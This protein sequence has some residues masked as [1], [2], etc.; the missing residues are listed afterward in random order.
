MASKGT[1]RALA[2]LKNLDGLVLVGADAENAF[3]AISRINLNELVL[4]KLPAIYNWFFTLYGYET[5][6][7]YDAVHRLM[8]A[9]GLFQ[10]VASSQTFFGAGKWS[11]QQ[12]TYQLMTMPRELELPSSALSITASNH[13]HNISTNA[14][15]I[16]SSNHNISPATHNNN[17]YNTSNRA[18]SLYPLN[19]DA[20]TN[21]NNNNNILTNAALN[22]SATSDGAV[23]DDA[24]YFQALNN[25]ATN[26]NHQQLVLNQHNTSYNQQ[27]QHNIPS[28]EAMERWKS[29]GAG[30]E[31]LEVQDMSGF[32]IIFQTDWVDDGVTL[33]ESKF[34]GEYLKCQEIAYGEWHL[35][36]NREKTNIIQHTTNKYEIESTKMQCIQY[37]Y[38][39][40]GEL[41]YLGIQ[42]GPKH[43][44][45]KHLDE[46]YIKWVKK[47]KYF[48]L[49]KDKQIRN[50]LFAKFF[51]F[52]KYHY[53]LANQPFHTS[54]LPEFQKV[55]KFITGSM[56]ANVNHSKTAKVQI[57]IA[58]KRGGLGMRAPIFY[59]PASRLNALSVPEME[60]ERMFDFD[61]EQMNKIDNG[62]IMDINTLTLSCY[63]Q[64]KT[65]KLAQE[66]EA[67]QMVEQIKEQIASESFDYN[68]EHVS[69]R[70]LLQLMDKALERQFYEIATLEDKARMKSLSITGATSWLRTPPNPHYGVKYN[71]L[72]YTVLTA[73]MLGAPILQNE[74]ICNRCSKIC[75]KYG[76]HALICPNGPFMINRHNNICGILEG[77]GKRAGYRVE[78]EVVVVPNND[79]TVD[80]QSIMNRKKPGDLKYFNWK[81]M[82]GVDMMFDLTVGSIFCKTYKKGAAQRRFYV[83]DEK[84]K[85]KMRKYRNLDLQNFEVLAIENAGGMSKIFRGV[86]QELATRISLYKST[87]YSI[88][89]NQLRTKIVATLMKHNAKMIIASM[90]CT[91]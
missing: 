88:I 14:I 86:L 18:V 89:I 68:P 4:A 8:A 62:D 71:N 65:A 85:Q 17:N 28:D 91:E 70:E 5:T 33:I 54:F 84:R 37:N 7:D 67:Q 43:V 29:G 90:F 83:C 15:S 75:D 35:N 63:Q 38:N 79:P 3:G 82:D 24:A 80:R 10:G 46:I 42:Y 40:I 69:H 13:N 56:T 32:R 11:V 1:V 31:M 19:D 48:E 27:N 2:M 12:R 60:I 49:I 59:H 47:L 61:E 6:V 20:A 30:D 55:Y 23:L 50:T 44:V 76:Y 58:Q 64:Y 21:N 26:T 52:N 66:H 77:E 53:L 45:I 74:V 34:L 36:I 73:L 41:K 22:N 81:E 78:R 87:P 57:P 51:D 16:G 9:A 39:S 72:E 25:N